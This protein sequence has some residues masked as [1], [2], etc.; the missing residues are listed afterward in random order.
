MD[1][2][3]I[4]SQN[5]KLSCRS[6]RTVNKIFAISE[7]LKQVIAQSED[8]EEEAKANCFQRLVEVRKKNSAFQKFFY[9]PA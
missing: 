7:C 3:P 4:S 6:R 2:V 9:A 1:A 5:I 8:I